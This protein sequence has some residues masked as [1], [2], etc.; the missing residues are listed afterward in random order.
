M[1]NT[2]RVWGALLC[3]VLLVVAALFIWG[4]ALQSYWA[5]AIP[6]IIGFLG[7]LALGFWIGWTILTIKTTPPTPEPMPASSPAQE[8]KAAGEQKQ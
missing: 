7:V 2:S 3:A 5:L 6:V 4:V 1:A 8:E